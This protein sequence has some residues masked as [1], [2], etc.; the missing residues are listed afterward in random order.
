MTGVGADRSLTPQYKG[1]TDADSVAD[2]NPPEGV[3]I[4]KK[5]VTK[6]DEAYWKTYRAAPKLVFS[7]ATAEKLWGGPIGNVTSLRI[8]A[9]RAEEF[10]Q[11]LH[12]KL[13]PAAMGL[14]FQ[15]IMAQQLAASGGSTDFGEYFIYFSFFIIFAAVL[16]VA[17]LFRLNVEQ[18]ARQ[19]GLLSAVGLG[20]WPLRRLALSEGMTLAAIGGLLG[21]PAAILYT[22]FIMYGLRT[23]WIGAV[24]TSS[25]YLHVA[26]LTLLYGYVGS[27]LVA[28][29]A[30]LWAAWRVGRTS[31]ATLLAGGWGTERV[32]R[33][34]G[35]VLR[36][37]G[38][39][40]VIG[41]I[42]I[43]ASARFMK[44]G[45]DYAFLGGGTLLLVGLLCGIGGIL[46]PGMRRPA[47]AAGVTAVLPAVV[48]MTMA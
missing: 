41:A 29:C 22:W 21:I 36:I 18:R 46:R 44:E 39:V 7:F 14:V 35:R 34:G 4:D 48:L 16:L 42:A 1:L 15:P 3:E 19:L 43:F 33:S 26:P 2:W 5:L 28:F 24:G 25:L 37:I 10:R 11:K 45:S 6:A 13:D 27:L 38:I 40:M 17:M 23:W 8:P 31:P 12:D 32:G 20:P 30:I 47:G 9:D